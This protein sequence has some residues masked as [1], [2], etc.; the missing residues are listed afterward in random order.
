[1][2][3]KAIEVSCPCCQSRLE[4][5]VRTATIVR[6]RRK[7][8]LDETGK[9][10]VSETDWSE[11]S[12]RVMKRSGSAAEKFDAGLAREKTRERDLDELFRKTREKLEDQDPRD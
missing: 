1:M 5:D 2:D 9:P 8:E 6:W 10:K 11:A 12:E 4:I 3:T 7:A